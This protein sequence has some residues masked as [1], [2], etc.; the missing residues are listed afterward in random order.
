MK[1]LFSVVV[2]K[3]IGGIESSLLN[4]LNNLCCD[5]EYVIDLCV[6]GN[7][8]SPTTVI[9]ENVHII[10]GNRILEYACSELKDLKKD[11]S[12]TEIIMAVLVKCLKKAIGYKRIL[13]FCL[14]SMKNKEKY[15]VAISF[16]NDKFNGEYI[17]GSDD[18]ILRCCDAQRKIAWIHN[19][20]R[21][22]GMTKEIC[23]AHYK[24]FD[25]VVNVS[26]GCKKIFDE[27][28]PEYK[29]KSKVVTNTLNLMGI[30]KRKSGISPYKSNGKI[31]L[32]TVARM[33]NQQ[34]RIDRVLDCCRKFKEEKINNVFWTV[35]G[36]GPDFE[37]LKK[38]AAQFELDDYLVFVGRKSN[39]IPYMQYADLFVQTSDYEAYSMVLIEAL[40][41]GCPCICTNYESAHNIIEND[42][43]GWLVEKTSEAIY[44]KI[45]ETIERMDSVKAM[46]KDCINSCIKLNRMALDSFEQLIKK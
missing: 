6:I 39:A 20:A 29:G 35:V 27:I 33:D 34:K 3:G 14:K 24:D 5:T 42:V 43:N 2:L 19:D 12:K 10:Q 36:D 13:N 45:R 9:P 7:Y 21:Q 44:E 4:I 32:L 28:V 11:K 8:I 17:G 1:I 37:M 40:S 15:D 22:H 23:L 46:K 26:E 31:N 16:S 41:V 25:Y 18:Y 38:Q 30:E